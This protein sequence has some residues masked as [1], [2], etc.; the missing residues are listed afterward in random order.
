M[1]IYPP[2]RRNISEAEGVNNLSQTCSVIICLW[3]RIDGKYTV[4]E[5]LEVY[6]KG[7]LQRKT[8]PAI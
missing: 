6:I 5:Y 3:T 1:Q 2:L 7:Y 8:E 4:G